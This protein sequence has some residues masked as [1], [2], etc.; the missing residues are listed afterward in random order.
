[1]TVQQHARLIRVDSVAVQYC[2]PGWELMCCCQLG[3]LALLSDQGHNVKCRYLP[4]RL[5]L[6]ETGG[7]NQVH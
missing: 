5:Q 1:M 4:R 2:C 3:V 7:L 6:L